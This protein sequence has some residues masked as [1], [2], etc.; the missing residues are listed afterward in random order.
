MYY[1]KFENYII[2][3]ALKDEIP[4]YMNK[5]LS[6]R[7]GSKYMDMEVPSHTDKIPNVKIEVDN[8]KLVDKCIDKI[9]NH[10]HTNIIKQFKKSSIFKLLKSDTTLRELLN[11]D[12]KNLQLTDLKYL[13]SN[14]INLLDSKTKEFSRNKSNLYKFIQS[15]NKAYEKNIDWNPNNDKEYSGLRDIITNY[16]ENI[17]NIE[18]SKLYL[19]ISDKADD[20]LRMSISKFYDSCQNIYT[21]GES[22]NMYNLHLLSNVFDVNSKIA[23][24]MFDVEFTDNRGNIHPYTPIARTIIRYNVVDD[25]I[26]FD[27][28]YPFSA[29]K[30]IYNIIEEYTDLIDSGINDEN[31][32][33]N[34]IEG[35]HNPYMDKYKLVDYNDV[36][37]N[38]L[39]IK[40]LSNYFNFDKSDVKKYDNYEYILKNGSIY[41]CYNENESLFKTKEYILNN[42]SII[43]DE[44]SIDDIIDMKWFNKNKYLVDV[45]KINTNNIT[46]IFDLNKVIKLN[47]YINIDEYV[48]YYG[49]EKC[50]LIALSNNTDIEYVSNYKD[51]IYYIYKIK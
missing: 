12:V 13:Y 39:K 34:G 28:T 45:R 51:V 44:N 5:I 31:Y 7:H 15:Y 41:S 47:K 36:D 16:D 35:L 46:N 32:Y 19:Y 23:Y 1:L 18:N 25:K 29:T 24:L 4:S 38:K 9:I 27:K 30:L 2:M 20:K 21:G 40:I 37:Y 42:F 10:L 49:I 26:M 50:R 33:I 6:K 14:D 22:G 3:E 43:Y 8:K 11:I 48:S 17:N